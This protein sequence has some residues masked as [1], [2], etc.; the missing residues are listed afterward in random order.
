VAPVYAHRYRFVKREVFTLFP[1]SHFSDKCMIKAHT[2]AQIL[3]NISLKEQSALLPDFV[4]IAN[5]RASHP[6]A[7]TLLKQAHNDNNGTRK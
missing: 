2:V 1:G 4:E 5:F 6:L 3:C 7:R